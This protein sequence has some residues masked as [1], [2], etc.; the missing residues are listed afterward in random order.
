M[1]LGSIHKYAGFVYN[2]PITV[3][4]DVIIILNIII[5]CVV[6][7]HGCWP[8]DDDDDDDD[9]DNNYANAAVA[10]LLMPGLSRMKTIR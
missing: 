5:I 4:N 6:D 8:H 7:I 10:E 2:L 9:D 3:I 1:P